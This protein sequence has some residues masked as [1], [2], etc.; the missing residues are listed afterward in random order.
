MPRGGDPIVVVGEAGTLAR[1][2]I[3]NGDSKENFPGQNPTSSPA[4][5]ARSTPIVVLE[6]CDPATSY[7][8]GGKKSWEVGRQV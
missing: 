6:H 3:G 5:C 1:G 7:S 4:G 8:A 2:G